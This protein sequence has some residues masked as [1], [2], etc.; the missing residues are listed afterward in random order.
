MGPVAVVMY[1]LAV[2][3][4]TLQPEALFETINV[5]NPVPV[6]ISHVAMAAAQ[7]SVLK[8][9]V[10]VQPVWEYR[11]LAPHILSMHDIGPVFHI[12]RRGTRRTDQQQAG[13]DEQ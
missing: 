5:V 7:V 10:P 6:Q 13:A 9:P 4:A 12:M 11:C 3:P 1:D 2:K 8:L